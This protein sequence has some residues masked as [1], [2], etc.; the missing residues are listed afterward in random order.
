M[1]SRLTS[2]V[3][4]RAAA[5]RR[6]GGRLAVGQGTPRTS[7]VLSLASRFRSVFIFAVVA[8]EW[9]LGDLAYGS[10]ERILCGLVWAETT[11]F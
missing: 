6:P 9:G 10:S 11:N 3:S 7:G 8:D 4:R 2:G 1:L 5:A